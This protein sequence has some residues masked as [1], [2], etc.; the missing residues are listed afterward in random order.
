MDFSFSFYL[1]GVTKLFN[2][3]L[4]R[5]YYALGIALGSG[6]TVV[7]KKKKRLIRSLLSRSL[8]FSIGDGGRR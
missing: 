4:L 8:Q 6:Y 7:K 2:K 1:A 5:T 3:H